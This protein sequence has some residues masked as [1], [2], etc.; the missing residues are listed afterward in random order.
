[1]TSGTYPFEAVRDHL[2][3]LYSRLSTARDVHHRRELLDE[4]FLV[5]PSCTTLIEGTSVTPVVADGIESRWVVAPGCDTA[6][7]LLYIHGGSWCSGNTAAYQYVC[8]HIS[9]STGCAVLAIDYKLAPE[10]KYPEGLNDCVKA[11]NWLCKNGPEGEAVCKSVFISGDSAGGNLTLATYL[12]LRAQEK[13]GHAIRK[14]NGLMPV[15]AVTDWTQQGESFKSRAAVDPI[16]QEA[17][18]PKLHPVYGIGEFAGPAVDSK[19]GLKDPCVSPLFGDYSQSPPLFIMVGD[20]EVLLDDSVVLAKMAK[21]QGADVQ[22]KVYN[23]GVH[24]FIGFAP[25]LPEA[26]EAIQDMG[27][28]VRKHQSA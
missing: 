14:P 22:I 21:E 6:N 2:T 26:V 3:E 17:S 24:V 20:Y 13:D 16:L 5:D 7:R 28:F 15:S 4:F 27:E 1:M 23:K 9:E 12:R 25:Y 19:L 10:Y 8:S 18:L 11:Y